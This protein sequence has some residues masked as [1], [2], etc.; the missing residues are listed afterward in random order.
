MKSFICKVMTPQG[1]VIKIKLTEEDKIAC[2]KKLK[3]NGMTPIEVKPALIIPPNVSRRISSSIAAKKREEKVIKLSKEVIKSIKLEDIK[4]FTQQFLFLRQ[5]KFTNA[6]ALKTII[7][8]TKNQNFKN[9]LKEI[10]KNSEKNVFI[11]K[12]METYSQIFPLIYVNLIKNG[13]L[14]G[15]LDKGLKNAIEYLENEEKLDN[16][17]QE[18]VFPS[19]LLIF[20]TMLIMFLSIVLG[21]P[22]IQ[23]LLFN[24]NITLEL[25][26]ITK[27]VVN[28]CNLI[29]YKWYIFVAI[30]IVSI[31]LIVLKLRTPEGKLKLDKFKY[32]NRLFGKVLYLLDFSRLIGCLVINLE[33]KMRIQDSLEICKSVVKNSYMLNTIEKSINGIFKGKLWIEAFIEDK[34][35]D[36]IVIEMIKKNSELK[37]TE[38]ISKTIEYLERQIDKEIEKLIVRLTEISYIVLGILFLIYIGTVLLPCISVYLSSFLLF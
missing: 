18:K 20:A 31:L 29:V 35:L 37:S 15:S 27:I 5:S 28:I 32:N 13:E 10:L 7:T 1:Q 14:T 8:N 25:P 3:R 4:E 12:T 9:I 36:S 33:N 6:H 34:I 22:L 24:T 21:I 17:L 16:V 38:L 26:L 11:Y 23:D 30:L 19:I 2:L